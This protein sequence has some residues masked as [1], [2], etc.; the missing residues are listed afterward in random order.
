MLDTSLNREDSERE[1]VAACHRIGADNEKAMRSIESF[2]RTL[3]S[4]TPAQ[5]L[6]L[7]KHRREVPPVVDERA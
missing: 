2:R 1:L 5:L 3:D 4:T 7:L 6:P